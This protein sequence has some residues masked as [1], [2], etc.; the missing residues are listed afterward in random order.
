MGDGRRPVGCNASCPPKSK[1]LHSPTMNRRPTARQIGI[2]LG[3]L[4]FLYVVSIGPV[5]RYSAVNF[6]V[7]PTPE[8]QEQLAR[9][10][11]RTKVFTVV[12][13]PILKFCDI[14]PPAKYA[15]GRYCSLWEKKPPYP[16]FPQ[17]ART[18]VAP[19]LSPSTEPTALS[20]EN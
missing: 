15:L 9:L 4:L 18:Q 12:Y 7:P 3:I 13:A 10:K 5:E 20:T 1:P 8:K 6:S 2:L 17:A 16:H 11:E 19:N 14:C